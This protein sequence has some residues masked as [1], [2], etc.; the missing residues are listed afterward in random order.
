MSSRSAAMVPAVTVTPST[1]ATGKVGPEPATSAAQPGAPAPAPS[2]TKE[3]TSSSMKDPST[4]KEPGTHRVSIQTPSMQSAAIGKKESTAVEEKQE[5]EDTAD[6]PY[7][8]ADKRRQELRERLLYLTQ[9]RASILSERSDARPG[10]CEQRSVISQ[11]L[12]QRDP[13]LFISSQRRVVRSFLPPVFRSRHSAADDRPQRITSSQRRE[14][15]KLA[16]NQREMERM[17]STKKHRMPAEQE[18]EDRILR[19]RCQLPMLARASA[20]CHRSQL[21]HNFCIDV[22]ERGCHHA[23][24]E[25]YHILR[26]DSAQKAAAKAPA[27]LIEE[28][29]HKLQKL[30]QCLVDVEESVRRHDYMSAYGSAND[31]AFFFLKDPPDLWLANHFFDKCLEFGKKIEDDGKMRESEAHCNVGIMW[32]FEDNISA[33][34]T[35]LEKFRRLSYKQVWETM[36]NYSYYRYSCLLLQD[37]Y[38]SQAV[39][40]EKEDLEKAFKLYLR[41]SVMA[42]Q[43]QNM[44]A[45][46]MAQYNLGEIQEKMGNWQNALRRYEAYLR[47]SDKLLNFKGVCTGCFKIAKCH[48]AMGKLP[49]AVDNLK[50][51]EHIARGQHLDEEIIRASSELGHIYLSMGKNDQAFRQFSQ[52]W[53]YV[54]LAESVINDHSYVASAMVGI[55]SAS[56]LVV[57]FSDLVYRAEPEQLQ[58]LL[59]WRAARQGVQAE[60]APAAQNK[61][62]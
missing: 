28:T 60:E 52:A 8:L 35:H 54:E 17:F 49:L 46:A 23:H 51:S 27:P 58:S 42:N 61:W 7:G 38:L 21:K 56:R 34:L 10:A 9:P 32:F 6:D 26:R 3:P 55:S 53:N 43:A 4:E 45:E 19:E 41:A 29:P 40:A 16:E 33:A 18:L 14:P 57:D 2:A 31:L 15:E 47:L 1:N 37:V 13:R 50:R 11:Y 36:D 20:H 39:A 30:K 44:Q 62:M 24:T 5:G 25:M 48:A 22:L 59:L 12:R